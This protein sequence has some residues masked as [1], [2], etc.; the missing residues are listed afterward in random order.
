MHPNNLSHIGI[1]Y[2]KFHLHNKQIMSYQEQILYNR[3]MLNW[4]LLQGQLQKKNTS[5]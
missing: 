4:L 1:N 5:I 3:I 2:G